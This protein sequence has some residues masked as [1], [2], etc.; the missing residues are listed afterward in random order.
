MTRVLDAI[1]DI[2]STFVSQ[3]IR[4]VNNFSTFFP[5]TYQLFFSWNQIRNSLSETS[6]PFVTSS[7]VVPL[8]TDKAFVVIEVYSVTERPELS[9]CFNLQ[10]K[11][12][13][14]ILL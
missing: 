7:S 4:D 3:T 2:G 12:K 14:V 10:M 13:Y 11:I 6:R 1:L 5:C 9:K 8:G